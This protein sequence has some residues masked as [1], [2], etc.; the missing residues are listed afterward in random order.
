MPIYNIDLGYAILFDLAK[1]DVINSIDKPMQRNN[2]LKKFIKIRKDS[3]SICKNLE[4]EDYVVQPSD[5]VSPIK[6]HLGHTSWF[7][8][9]IILL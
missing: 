7:F 1:Y 6:W 3:I 5:E 8:E 4:I 2:L 9:E